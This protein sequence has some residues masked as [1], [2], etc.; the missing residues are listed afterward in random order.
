[1]GEGSDN[2]PRT[3]ESGPSDP[4]RLA[5]GPGTW[6]DVEIGAPPAVVWA[7]VTDLNLPAEFSGEFTG[8]DWQGE[9][10]PGATFV[11]RNTHPAI[12]DWEVTCYVDAWEPELAFGWRTSDRDD[13]GARWRF[14]LRPSAAGT[15]LRYSVTVGPGFSGLAMAI[16]SS[17]DKEPRI[18]DRR[19]SELHGNMAKVVEGVRDHAESMADPAG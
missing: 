3:Y 12:G 18:I 10:G 15:S 9:P 19:L 11:G 13:P 8:A 2:Q 4:V 16:A 14:D 17:P 7:L 1:M 5:D 6:V